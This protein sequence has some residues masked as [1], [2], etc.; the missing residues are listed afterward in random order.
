VA[1]DPDEAIDLV[2]EYLRE[3]PREQV[4]DKLLVP[5]LGMARRD[6]ERGV[7]TE[8]EEQTV[9][10]EM[11]Q[12]LEEI[13]PERGAGLVAT[14]SGV[15]DCSESVLLGCPADGEADELAL[16]MLGQLLGMAGCRFEVLSA[17]TLAAELLSR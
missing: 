3:H 12:I 17:D 14:P 9:Y 10:R 15:V 1:R 6:R 13:V 2:E 8:E 11:R 16:L 7:L 5:A 4:Y